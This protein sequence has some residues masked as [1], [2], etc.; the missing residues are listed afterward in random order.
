MTVP[1][2]TNRE[3]LQEVA[4]ALFIDQDVNRFAEFVSDET[5]I[6]HNP[7]IADGKEAALAF[8]RPVLEH[9]DPSARVT[10]VLVD[11][12]IGVIHAQVRGLD[13]RSQMNIVDMF[14]ISDGKLVEHWDVMAPIKTHIHPHQA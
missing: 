14:R 7:A 8:L 9:K 3:L 4:K 10:H 1:A 13:G 12:D 5:Y 2:R 6:Q 11:G